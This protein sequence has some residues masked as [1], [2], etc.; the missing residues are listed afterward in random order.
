MI[1]D[2]ELRKEDAFEYLEKITNM[3]DDRFLMFLAELQELIGC[4]I[5]K[6]TY[7]ERSAF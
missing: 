7:V 3:T 5:V 1:D 6:G 4:Q 2:G